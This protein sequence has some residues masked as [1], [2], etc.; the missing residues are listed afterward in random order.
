MKATR[1]F[2]LMRAFK[3]F[4]RSD[5]S[6]TVEA[7]LIMPV[8]LCAF[9]TIIFIIKAV[10]TYDMVQHAIDGAACEMASSGY[11]YHMSGI[12]SLHDTARNAVN[13]RAD[14][15][16]SQIG[17]V[18]DSYNSIKNI[19]DGMFQGLPDISDSAELISN[20]E[21]SFKKMLA[22]G[23][24]IIENP[25]DELKNIA[26]YFA[27]DTLNDAKT[28]LFIPL[29]KLYMKK[30]LATGKQEDVDE[31]LERLNIVDGFDGL[32]FSESSFFADRQENIDIV[33][34]YKI[35]LPLPIPFIDGLQIVQR[36]K[37]KAWM[38]G[39]ELINSPE[40][41]DDIWSLSNFQRGRKI[42]R[43]F[44][45]NLPSNFPVISKFENGKA[46][47]IKSMDLTAASYQT[48]DNAKNTLMGYVKK[49]S[50]FEGQ[51]KPWGAD[52]I[53]IKKEEIK[54]K[55][56]FLVIPEN[57]LSDE[58][59]RLLSDMEGIAQTYG[60]TLVVKRY[61]TKV[62]PTEQKLVDEPSQ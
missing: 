19:K 4:F 39:D 33:V 59:E 7:A 52:G 20:A 17:S 62:L 48:G 14:V 57:E 26:C 12:R 54:E 16:K 50:S 22:E 10:Y 29:V 25:V 60:I 15:F 45:A 2:C 42:Q 23:E 31:K 21:E 44:G 49:L 28:Q 47:M 27:S 53:V 43:I 35:M 37:A 56:L 9:F 11:I 51:E 61:G 32:D 8:V 38:E 13:D 6:V 30:Y 40:A 58:N 36:S 24:Q 5:G 46:V 41:F 1:G 55:E 3:R 34:R 18:F